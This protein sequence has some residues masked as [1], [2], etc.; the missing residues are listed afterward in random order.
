MELDL[1]ADQLV[2][3]ETTE[4]FLADKASVAALRALRH[5]PV[6][7]DRDYWRQGTEL[8]WTSLLVEGEFGGGNISGRG[9][10]D[11]ALVAYEFGRHAAPGPL[12]SNNVVAAAI[13]RLGSDEQKK[14]RLPGILSGEVLASW[15]FAEPRPNQHLGT[16]VPKA[17]PPA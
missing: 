8:G 13:S 10:E 7:F 11:L 16:V 5:D 12:L 4:K 9:P 14:E 6:G 15:C 3:L 2:F 1:T 17:T